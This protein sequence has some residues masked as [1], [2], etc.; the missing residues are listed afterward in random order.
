MHEIS[1]IKNIFSTLEQEFSKEDLDKITVIHL[2]LGKLSNVEPVLMQNALQ[3]VTKT[4]NRFTHVSLEIEIIP[5]RIFC[6]D[7]NKYSIIENYSF[8][9]HY[10]GKANNNITDGEEL[11]ISKVL[12]SK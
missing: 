7:C 5:I 4:E 12:F 8:K 3:A 6:D 2:K 1:L 9:C 11:M 10:C